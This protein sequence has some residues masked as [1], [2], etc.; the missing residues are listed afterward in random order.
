MTRQYQNSVNFA[1]SSFEKKKQQPKFQDAL[2]VLSLCHEVSVEKEDGELKFNS[3]SPDEVALLNFAKLEG[4]E[5][6][7]E[8]SKIIKVADY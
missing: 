2:K 5:Y 7:G 8:E 6:L 4:K 1:D 3:S